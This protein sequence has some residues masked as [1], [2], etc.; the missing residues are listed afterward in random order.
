MKLLVD[1]MWPAR[2]AEQLRTR[3]HDVV[4][5]A[6]RPELVRQPD[7]VIFEAAQSERRAVLTENIADFR[8]LADT[9]LR[10]GRDFGGLVLTTDSKFPRGHPR[11]LGRAV[12][13]LDAFLTARPD[14]PSNRI[15][16]L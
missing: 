11:T 5:V 16:W 13:A 8:P 14:G 1:E 12:R 15:A 4:A 9:A 6:E 3:G 10:Q 7:A 2:L